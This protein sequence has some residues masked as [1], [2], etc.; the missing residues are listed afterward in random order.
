[1]TSVEGS[2]APTRC[3]V[4]SCTNTDVTPCAYVDR[5]QRPCNTAWCAQ[6]V[7]MVDGMALCRRHAGVVRAIGTEP[8]RL[9]SLP[10][11]ENRAPSLVSWVAHD[12]DPDVRK[13]LERYADTGT[14]IDESAIF[15]LGHV[16]RR[17]WTRHWKVLSHTGFDVRISLMVAEAEDTT[18]RASVDGTIVAELEPPWIA[19]RRSGLTLSPEEDEAERARF[20]RELID[21]VAAHLAGH[22]PGGGP[23]A[24]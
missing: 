11:L 16:T 9:V 13:L 1:M 14:T 2:A 6:H 12:V 17:T 24:T 7:V 15:P 3:T 23:G 4:A 21:A 22:R 5:R 8:D 10:D 18:V 19:R 20:R